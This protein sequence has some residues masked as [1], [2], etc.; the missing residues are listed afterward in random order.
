MLVRVF[1][2]L[3]MKGVEIFSKVGEIL[4]ERHR[5][6]RREQAEKK[7]SSKRAPGAQSG[8]PPFGGNSQ[9]LKTKQN[10]ERG[11]QKSQTPSLIIC[12]AGHRRNQA[13]GTDCFYA[14]MK[15]ELRRK[16]DHWLEFGQSEEGG[17]GKT[18][19]KRVRT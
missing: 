19:L 8:K 9:I 2:N 7:I 16:K 1:S 15:G 4:R 18:Y 11:E 17:G 5:R 12:G 14:E 3:G 13:A 10:T 6:S